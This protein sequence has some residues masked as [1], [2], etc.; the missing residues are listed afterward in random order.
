MRSL[1]A[2]WRCVR[3]SRAVRATW[4]HLS[5]WEVSSVWLWVYQH[6]I[7]SLCCFPSRLLKHWHSAAIVAP[8]VVPTS[9]SMPILSLPFFHRRVRHSRFTMWALQGGGSGSRP[10]KQQQV[11]LLQ[12][13][14][15]PWLSRYHRCQTGSQKVQNTYMF[16]RGWRTVSWISIWILEMPECTVTESEF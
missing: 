12:W 5:W 6:S 4:Q 2:S 9:F 3:M 8:I 14:N 13:D 1:T 10:F 16:H 7:G 15:D 11:A